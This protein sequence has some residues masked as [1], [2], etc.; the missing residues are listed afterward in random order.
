MLLKFHLD[1]KI[2]I[3]VACV[4]PVVTSLGFWQL[5]RAE[6][7]R[8][9]QTAFEQ[10][11]QKQPMGWSGIE[12][13]QQQ[14]Q[15]NS[16][17]L[18][19]DSSQNDLAFLPVAFEGQF[20][21]EKFILLDNKVLQGKVGYHVLQLFLVNKQVAIEQED[22][23]QWVLVNRGWIAAPRTRD[24]MPEIPKVSD[25]LTRIS[26]EVYVQPGE[27]YKLEEETFQNPTWPLVI[28][29]VEIKQLEKLLSISIF[30]Y[31]IRLAQTDINALEV[32][33]QALSVQP[34]KHV[35]YA[36]Q[37]FAMAIGIILWGLFASSNLW[38]WLKNFWRK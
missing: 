28:Q 9:I 35:G 17:A 31:E 2:L 4:L 18:D 10:Q 23:Q 6:E 12:A 37:W 29:N 11:R 36:V 34:E 22:K 25:G 8:S 1:V 33:W 3:L 16:E 19:Q 26:G 5:D 20:D 14:V 15:S 13:L 24:E 30:P 38:S 21:K 7:K 27:A 32:N